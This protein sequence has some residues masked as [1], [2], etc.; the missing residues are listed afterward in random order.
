MAREH[1]PYRVPTTH[2]KWS[3]LANLQSV[4]R[5]DKYQTGKNISAVYC[6]KC[7]E[8]LCLGECFENC[9]FEINNLEQVK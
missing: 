7:N 4:Y 8:G 1:S 2:A 6:Q 5:H 3:I 9:N